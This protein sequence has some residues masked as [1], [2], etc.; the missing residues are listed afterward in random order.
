MKVQKV[1]HILSKFIFSYL[2][3]GFFEDRWIESHNVLSFS[4]YRLC[5]PISPMHHF[6]FLATMYKPYLQ[7][8]VFPVVDIVSLI[9]EDSSPL[10]QDQTASVQP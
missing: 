6:S 4:F 2:F 7:V 1:N 9:P 3:L 10:H 5:M 8:G